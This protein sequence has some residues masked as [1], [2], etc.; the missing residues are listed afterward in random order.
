MVLRSLFQF[1]L[2]VR[3]PLHQSVVGSTA[4]HFPTALIVNTFGV[5]TDLSLLSFAS[6]L[7]LD[8]ISGRAYTFIASLE[9]FGTLVGIG[10]L[11]PIYQAFLDDST[12]SGGTPYFI[13]GVKYSFDASRFKRWTNTVADSLC[14]CCDNY[15]AHV[16]HPT[17]YRD[18][19]NA[20]G[21]GSKSDLSWHDTL[22]PSASRW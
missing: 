8:D 9:S 7:P 3:L 14:F 13:C 17:K 2:Q 18:R 10:I 21:R 6:G 1:L 22:L 15:L 4:D 20:N 5:A 11:Y 19:S 12:I 16:T